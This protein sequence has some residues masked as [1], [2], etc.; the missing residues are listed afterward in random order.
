[1]NAS[2]A[3]LRET[4]ERLVR[5]ARG[6]RASR[7]CSTTATSGPG[8]KF[9]DADLIGIPLRVTVGPRGAGARLRRGEAARREPR[10]REVPV[11][12]GGGAGRGT[13]RG[14]AR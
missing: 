13:L 12:R 10:R 6:A 11:G 8:V 9:K 14:A 4:A 1:M 2:D 3:A 5:G 7:C